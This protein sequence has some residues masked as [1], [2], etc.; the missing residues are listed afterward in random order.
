MTLHANYSS[1]SA[2]NNKNIHI[3][4]SSSLLLD[5]FSIDEIKS[6][7][8]ENK[9]TDIWGMAKN[10]EF[11]FSEIDLLRMI[12]IISKKNYQDSNGDK[13][14]NSSSLRTLFEGLMMHASNEI[15]EKIKSIHF[16][17][18]LEML[19]QE[20][21][22]KD[23]VKTS[24]QNTMVLISKNH[25]LPKQDKVDK[26]LGIFNNTDLTQLVNR[27]E[28]YKMKCNLLWNYAKFNYSHAVNDKVALNDDVVS[29]IESF[30]SYETRIDHLR[31]RYTDKWLI[32]GLMQITKKQLRNIIIHINKNSGLTYVTNLTTI[33][34]INSSGKK[35]KQVVNIVH[36]FSKIAQFGKG[37]VFTFKKQE[38]MVIQSGYLTI[39]NKLVYKLL[40][41][42]VSI[43][44][45]KIK[46]KANRI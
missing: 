8:A 7:I 40:L 18:L 1:I 45:K 14:T 25:H 15:L 34:R 42:L 20:L 12:C 27:E 19:S 24:Y 38:N 35:V 28:L 2:I 13:Y 31:L 11:V 3:N 46:Q 33:M 30:I 4:Y 23:F 9:Y 41:L 10:Y 17:D 29:L 32:E 22:Q 37:G 39:Y 16:H 21:L 5:I 6:K 26:L 36:A 43:I 44:K